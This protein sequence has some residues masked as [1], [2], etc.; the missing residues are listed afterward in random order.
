MRRLLLLLVLVCSVQA[1]PRFWGFATI[2]NQTVTTA[3]IVSTTKVQGS[4]PSI[5][6]TVYLT[7]TLTPATIFSDNSGTPKA[8][9]FTLNP[10]SLGYWFF[11][12]DS[13]S[14][15]DVTFTGGGIPAPF[16][17]SDLSSTD[18]GSAVW[19]S[20]TGTLANQTDLQTALNAKQATITTGTTAQYFRGD[21][22]LATLDTLAVPENTNLYFTNA[23]ARAAV[24]GSAPIS[25]NSATG[26]FSCPTCLTSSVVTSVFTRTGAVVA[27]TG[28]YTAA[29]VTNAVD[30]TASY[31]NP[32]WITSLAASKVGNGT[33]QWNA[34]KI[35]G[36][37]VA[38]TAP[39]D[40]QYLGWN[41]GASQ[42][43][44][45][46]TPTGTPAGSNNAI[47]Y[48][49]GGAFGG[50][51]L[52][53]TA[54]RKFLVQVSSAVALFDTLASGDIPAINLAA[55]GA[56]GVTGNL[57]V[58]NLNSGTSA[59]NTH[60][61]RGDATWALPVVTF[62]NIASGTNTT[63]TMTCGTG[64]TVTVSGSGVNNANQ[65][66]GATVPAS[67]ALLASN[68]SNQ[69]VLAAPFVNNAQTA[70]YQVLAADFTNYKTITVASGTFTITLVASGSQPVNGNYITILNYG[71]GVVT[72]ARSGQN[73]NG[74]AANL[75][76]T[77]GS[78]TAPTGW[79]VFSDGANYFAEVIGGG[80][81]GTV[82]TTG[83]PSNGNLTKFSGASTITNGDLS[84]DVSTSGTLTTT[85]AA[86]AVGS[87]KMAVVNTRRVCSMVIGAENGS[88]I[89]DGDLGP[90]GQ[91]CKVAYAA[92]VVEIDVNADAG[93]PNVIVRKKHC[94]TFT[95]GVCTSWT[96]TDLLSSAL[97]AAASNFDA[98]SN[99]GG[100][101]GLDGG[102]TCSATLQ[103]TSLAIGDWIELKSGTA[104]G[105][106]KRMSIDV[107]FTVN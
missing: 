73:I 93:T 36:R 7:D 80:G 69:I 14:R 46:T 82:T 40:L 33:A 16:T 12:A 86:N 92:T 59:D 72:L 96:S 52:N 44:P 90:Q 62:P 97:A 61:W 85:I 53:A 54:T 75:T 45:K 38:S 19:G 43:E 64:C 105:V 25:Y 18:G 57:P 71:T 30:Q 20:I 88:A 21:L 51:A 104:G 98:C 50:I 34:N 5:T 39:T 13:T 24:S 100:T 84:G 48:N 42:W 17:L 65:V 102:T 68:G 3:G 70:T 55:S 94:A 11:Y 78:A 23:R 2:G 106:A 79:R 49:N 56:G 99:T 67:A 41:A 95:T 32:S 9:P 60:F 103:N 10:A 29:Q 107:V 83:S 74:A 66:N 15:Y 91:Q 81:A 35:Q 8:N 37:A 58:T 4:Y 26:V 76:G 1:R 27:T 6:V 22:S 89:V 87:S 63:A 77:A 31:A 101:T 47:Q 28:D